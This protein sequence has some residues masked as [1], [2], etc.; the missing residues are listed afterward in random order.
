M[1]RGE[2]EEAA[3]VIAALDDVDID[4]PSVGAQI[5]DI[6]AAL[7]LTGTTKATDVLSNRTKGRHFWRASLGFWS[8]VMQQTTGIN[9]ITYYA[10]TVYQQS[11]G[12]SALNSKIL[13][14]TYPPFVE[15][16][17]A[18]AELEL[19][20]RASAANGTEYFLASFIAIWTIEKV[21]RRKL[22]LF[23]AS[24]QALTMA[25]LVVTVYLATPLS[26]TPYAG[27]GSASAGI[28]AA[29]LL[30][31]FNTFFAVGWLGMTWLYPSEINSLATRTAANGISTAGNWSL[32]LTTRCDG[33]C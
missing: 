10:A 14:G 11:I 23:G 22:M 3:R 27:K 16:V 1:K 12:L 24:G 19:M 33:S 28:G 17:T 2:V 9:L 13:A 18:F 25:L 7:A 31:V 8:Q 21:G 26:G 6:R 4:D 30:F 20:T 32:S 5:E 29:F 15:G